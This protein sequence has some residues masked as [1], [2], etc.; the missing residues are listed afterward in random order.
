M[1]G[2]LC[3]GEFHEN[4]QT[5]ARKM[6]EHALMSLPGRATSDW[7]IRGKKFQCAQKQRLI[8]GAISSGCKSISVYPVSWFG[9]GDTG[10]RLCLSC[11]DALITV[12]LL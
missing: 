5:P 12:E 2:I 11:V 10:I 3:S 4:L 7:K 1:T 9:I 6:L 8:R